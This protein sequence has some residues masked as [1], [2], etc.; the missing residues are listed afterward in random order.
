MNSG[1]T[2]F[3][4]CN[5][6]GLPEPQ[7]P[8][9]YRTN[10]FPSQLLQVAAIPYVT[11]SFVYENPAGLFLICYSP[12]APSS[13]VL[14]G[15]RLGPSAFLEEFVWCIPFGAFQFWMPKPRVQDPQPQAPNP[16]NQSLLHV[17]PG[18]GLQ[19]RTRPP[20][21]MNMVLWRT[22]YS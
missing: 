5:V 16:A 6:L 7:V 14:L 9:W 3:L 1:S 10:H 15:F 17:Q 2:I 11:L 12:S 8:L 13:V 18:R 22:L 21:L 19:T 4:K 20:E